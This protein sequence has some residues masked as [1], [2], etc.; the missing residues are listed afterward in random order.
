[1]RSHWLVTV[2]EAEARLETLPDRFVEMMRHGTMSVELYAPRGRDLQ[3]PHDQDELYVVWRG[4]GQFSL[5]GDRRPFGPGDVI[6]VPA[7]AEHRFE[8]FTE[9]FAAWVIFW[10]P[11]GGETV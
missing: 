11:K 7:R 10:G 3:T 9:D 1:M 6:F 5:R 8:T 4:A 2:A